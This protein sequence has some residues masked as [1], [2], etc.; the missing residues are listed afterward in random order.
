MAYLADLTRL[1]K[2]RIGNEV[3]AEQFKLTGR[4]Q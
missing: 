4:V 2:T 3:E 1:R